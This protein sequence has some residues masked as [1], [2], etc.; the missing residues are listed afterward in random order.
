MRERRR[1]ATPQEAFWS[2]EF[3]TNYIARNRGD[4]LLASNLAFF[5]RALEHA[6]LLA[7]CLEIGANVGMNL[8]AL[9]LLYPGIRLSAV[10]INAEAARELGSLIGPPNVSCCPI[11]DWR[12]HE[13]AELALSKGVLIHLSPEHLPRAYD[14]LHE[15]S[16]R[17]IL[18][19]EY[20]SPTPVMVTYRGHD[21]RL[22][23]RD[24]AGEML[25]RFA[26][27]RLLDYGFCY[28]RDPGFPQDDINWFL[29]E[30]AG[31]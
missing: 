22:F 4:A 5:G 21:D 8:K 10:E 6:G 12:P 13:T 29:L 27:L 15:A 1:S 3:G 28:R 24:F 30:K 2:G 7:S 31:H 23:K 14:R 9:S 19:A 18:I 25:D 11:A 20:Y 16:S 26:D 17:L